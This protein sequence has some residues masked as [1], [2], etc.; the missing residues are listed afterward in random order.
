MQRKGWPQRALISGS[1]AALIA[2]AG[3]AAAQ[4]GTPVISPSPM[5]SP[6]A[7]DSVEVALVDVES[8]LVGTGTVSASAGQVVIQISGSEIEPGEH[9]IHIHEFGICSPEGDMPFAS[10]G[11][12]YNPTGAPH[13]GPDDAESHAG[14]LGNLLAADDGTFT[15]Q[16]ATD[17]VSLDPGAPNTLRD[18]D[19]S[20]LVIHDNADD[21]MTDPS[22]N[23]GG[24]VACGIIYPS[25]TAGTPVASPP[26]TP[27]S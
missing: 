25:R 11:G 10:A 23:S 22:G 4:E 13:G 24:R 1:F 8:N 7:T 19:G 2:L 15:F 9:G 3:V 21:M 20:A 26:A 14:D 18:A 6:I 5:A 27:A 17:K 12:H 16:I